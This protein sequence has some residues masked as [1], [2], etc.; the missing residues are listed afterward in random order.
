MNLRS[1]SPFRR[2][3]GSGLKRNIL[4]MY[5][6]QINPL[7]LISVQSNHE[8]EREDGNKEVHDIFSH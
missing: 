1:L 7:P 2:K 5:F 8:T 3:P 6:F 4:A